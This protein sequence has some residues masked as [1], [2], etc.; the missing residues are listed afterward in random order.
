METERTGKQ[1]TNL[2]ISG[3][4]E[5]GFYIFESAQILLNE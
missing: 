1:P 5:V 3:R 4:F 2:L